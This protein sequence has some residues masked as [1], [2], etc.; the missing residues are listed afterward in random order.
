MSEYFVR[1]NNCNCHPDWEI[2]NDDGERHSTHSRQETAEETCK[3][4]NGDSEDDIISI[5]WSTDDIREA[6]EEMSLADARVVL[7]ALERG[8]DCNLG[9]N[10]DVI[11][12]T[13]ALLRDRKEIA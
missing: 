11:E 2:V 12:Y 6:H 3:A 8:H 4:L 13:V 5:R 9:I 10:W 1:I 7:K